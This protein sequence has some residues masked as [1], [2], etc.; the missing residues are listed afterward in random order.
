MSSTRSQC[1]LPLVK[2][3]S[4]NEWV[5]VTLTYPSE[6]YDRMPIDCD[7]ISTEEA[8]EVIHMRVAMREH[9]RRLQ[10]QE[11]ERALKLKLSKTKSQM[12][13]LPFVTSETYSTTLLY[14]DYYYDVQ[15]DLNFPH[16]AVYA[17]F[18]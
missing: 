7:P 12:M 2:R 6:E 15:N 14:D 13:D 10:Q 11:Y 4:F 3:V 5:D 16:S 8:M 18:I 9:S 17:T 1:G